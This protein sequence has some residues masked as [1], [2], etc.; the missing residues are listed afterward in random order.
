MTAAWCQ[1]VASCG[2]QTKGVVVC[3]WKPGT[4]ELEVEDWDTGEILTVP[5]EAG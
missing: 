5:L 2:G 3:R 4:N 1:L